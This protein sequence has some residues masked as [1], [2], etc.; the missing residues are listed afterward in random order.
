MK[1]PI[2]VKVPGKLMIAGEFAVLEP[3]HQLGVMAVDRF[4]YAKIAPSSENRLTLED[5]DLYDI[6]F[7]VDSNNV[8]VHTEDTNVRFVHNAIRVAIQYLQ[9]MGIAIST[10]ALSVRSELDDESG[11]KYGLGSSAAVVTAT[12]T[13]VLEV[14]LSNRPSRELIF[15]LAAIAHVE[16]QGNGSGA[17]IA[18]STFGGLLNYTSFQAEWLLRKYKHADTITEL[19][20]MDWVYFSVRPAT[21]VQNLYFCVGW[22]GEPASTSKLVDQILLLKQKNPAQFEE[23]LKQSDEAVHTFF[24]GMDTSNEGL[25]IDGVKRNRRALASVGHQANT[26]IE[27]PMLTKLCDL[28][29]SHGGAGKPSGAGGGDCGIAFIPSKEQAK[30]LMDS[31]KEAGIK[32]L[33]LHPMT[34]GATIINE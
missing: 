5:F 33:A 2:T 30:M 11:A 9:E 3:N 19:L 27:T 24:N 20:H 14:H 13:A 4:V 12:V 22:T 21:M 17:D 29:E 16:T 26:S 34:S 31:W 32:P 8:Y 6:G 23:F 28:A 25:I 1:S 7:D 15:K 18:A 10:F